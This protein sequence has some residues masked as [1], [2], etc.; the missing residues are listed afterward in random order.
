[1]QLYMYCGPHPE[2]PPAHCQRSRLQSHRTPDHC[3][4]G[5]SEAVQ[6]FASAAKL[7]PADRYA[8]FLSPGCPPH[9][10]LE[11]QASRIGSRPAKV[12]GSSLIIRY[13]ITG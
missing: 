6:E 3:R 2:G 7:P 5:D 1:M 11:S 9:H 10:G 13:S 8:H 12:F 4:A